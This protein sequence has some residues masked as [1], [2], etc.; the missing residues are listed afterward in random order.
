MTVASSRDS[1]GSIL[2]R[3]R[4]IPGFRNI[5]PAY[6]LL[7][8]YA[9]LNL[10]LAVYFVRFGPEAGD[11]QLWATLPGKLA[12]GDLY[13]EPHPFVWSPVAAWLLVVVVQLG[14]WAWFA[15]HLAVVPLLRD[16]WLIA[17][18]L[19]SWPFWHDAAEGN[20]FVF[21][22]V[23]G[24]LALRGSRAAALVY[25]V[26]LVLMPRPVQ[27]PL[28]AWLLWR[29]AD[30]RLPFA[31][32]FVSHAG[33]VLASGYALAW[34][35]AVRLYGSTGAM[36]NT[37]GP[38]RW[39]GPAWLAIGIPLGAWLWW[40]GRLGLAGIAISP[41][42]IPGYLLMWLLELVPRPA[43]PILSQQ[44]YHAEH[45]QPAVAVDVSD[46]GGADGD[47]PGSVRPGSP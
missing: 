18:T 39:F 14:Y 45:D 26:L 11:W 7:A 6:V 17:F 21:V 22:F 4:P 32:L 15:L 28:G 25:L 37:I 34:F 36:M 27:A 47:G 46:Q 10:G 42:W 43:R 23:S 35:E 31:A 8:C 30:L 40:R 12:R 9:A 2:D 24:A 19:A 5:R 20:A 13:G 3:L 29:M 41:Y 16:R 33:V 1:A 44:A 38:P